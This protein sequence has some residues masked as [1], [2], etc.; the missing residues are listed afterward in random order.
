[1]RVDLKKILQS[2]KSKKAADTLYVSDPKDARLKAY[3]DSLSLHNFYEKTYRQRKKENNVG[4]ES[5]FKNFIGLNQTNQPDNT[6][7]YYSNKKSTLFKKNEIHPIIE[8][9]Y[10]EDSPEMFIDD[11]YYPAKKNVEKFGFRFKKPV[12][13]VE[14]RKPQP[15]K[16]VEKKQEISKKQDTVIQ[17]KL[18]SY[19]GTPVYSPGAGSGMPSAL[20]G[21]MNKK[22][23]V[24][25]IQPEDFDRF[26]VPSY[27]KKYIESKTKKK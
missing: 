15:K 19:E 17:K 24:K 27:G 6:A 18:N 10:K 13:P 11:V 14:Y 3:Q 9:S 20:I 21:F 2:I 1:M 4:T 12:Q 5:R 26:A 7:Q 23:D 16:E 25:Y 22:G 8:Y